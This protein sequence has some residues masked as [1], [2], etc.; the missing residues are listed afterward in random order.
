MDDPVLASRISALRNSL[1]LVQSSLNSKVWQTLGPAGAEPGA[2][3]ARPAATDRL[4][5]CPV[6]R[7]LE[8]SLLVQVDKQIAAL[9]KLQGELAAAVPDDGNLSSALWRQYGKVMGKSEDLLRECLEIL[10][11]LA[12][13]HKDLD[14][15]CLDVAEQLILD[16]VGI[17]SNQP[18][19]HLLVPCLSD[20]IKEA[21][22]RVIRLRFPEWTIW[23]LPLL[24]HDAGRV[25]IRVTKDKESK[26]VVDEDDRDLTRFLATQADALLQ[27]EP[28]LAAGVRQGGE[29]ADDAGKQA[30]SRAETLLADAYA[31]LAL[32][33]AYACSAIRLRLSPAGAHE[34]AAHAHR[35]EIILSVLGWMDG[36]AGGYYLPFV[37]RLRREWDATLD[38]FDPQL[39]PTAGQLAFLRQYASSFVDI[40]PRFF[41][42]QLKYP[43]DAMHVGWQ[44]ALQWSKR[45]R[46]ELEEG[47]RLSVPED[48]QPENLRDVFNATWNCR[49]QSGEKD[50]ST[51]ALSIVGQAL[52]AR[53][54][55]TTTTH[56]PIPSAR[57]AVAG[58]QP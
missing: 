57:T 21:Q 10:G 43:S 20:A 28:D 22:A 52:S 55:D 50:E 46:E 19:F 38:R 45:W 17:S 27:Q 16:C 14:H 44:R 37:T 35:A 9:Q 47:R 3:G 49:F 31:T 33:P 23:D 58:G 24:G 7:D 42:R 4:G 40:Y 53:I 30:R 5:N 13:R 34:P 41:R 29:A 39:R 54:L 6:W 36:D 8:L 26:P 2:A 56:N 48:C 32:G 51:R 25:A 11:T 18:E 12:M 1:Q 15:R